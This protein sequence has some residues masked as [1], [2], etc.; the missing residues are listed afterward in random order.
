MNNR[1]PHLAPYGSTRMIAA[2]ETATA[3]GNFARNNTSRRLYVQTVSRA[4]G[5][6]E[7]VPLQV[8]VQGN[9]YHELVGFPD[10]SVAFPA[11]GTSGTKAKILRVLPCN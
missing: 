5:A 2:W 3:T 1:A 10:G 7:G 8:A 6:P 9:R 4:N 11:P